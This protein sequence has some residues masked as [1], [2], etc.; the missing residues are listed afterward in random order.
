M[1]TAG[2]QEVITL[3]VQVDIGDGGG[4][5]RVVTAASQEVIALS[6]QVHIGGGGGG[7]WSLLG[8]RRLS[9]CLYR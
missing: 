5:G 6:V 4:G 3:S 9:P 8:V 1:V 7:G 2:G